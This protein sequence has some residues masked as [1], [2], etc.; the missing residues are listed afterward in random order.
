MRVLVLC[1]SGN[2]TGC[3]Y[4]VAKDFSDKCA[5]RK[6]ETKVVDLSGID[7]RDCD[8]C[9]SCKGSGRCVFDDGMRGLCDEIDSADLLVLATP[10]R[11]N[12]VSS[13]M[14]RFIDRL[15]PYWHSERR[16]PAHACGII[17]A[18]SQEPTFT[19]A[20]SELKSAAYVLGSE[21]KG[22]LLVPDT[23]A[24]RPEMG[25]VGLFAEEVL[26]VI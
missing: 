21:W 12:G 4:A 17:V 9:G 6:H 11:F 18:G 10:L 13:I 14:K 24:Q 8:G 26:G 7:F 5:S 25:T 23:D 15:N 1:A 19:H 3:T 22:E 16:G 20:L 2:T